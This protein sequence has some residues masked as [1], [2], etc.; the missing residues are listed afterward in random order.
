MVYS[1]IFLFTLLSGIKGLSKK[2][3]SKAPPAPL[4]HLNQIYQGCQTCNPWTLSLSPMGL[5]VGQETWGRACQG[6][7]GPIVHSREWQGA[8]VLMALLALWL[9]ISPALL[10]APWIWTARVLTGWIW[11]GMEDVF[12]PVK[13]I[14]APVVRQSAC[15][16]CCADCYIASFLNAA[17]WVPVDQHMAT[18]CKNAEFLQTV[19]QTYEKT[20]ILGSCFSQI[21]F[22]QNMTAPQKSLFK[23]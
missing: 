8:A 17:H 23:N 11:L 14:L 16:T 5:L 21:G 20:S 1:F 19:C 4:L 9:L 12:H 3:R 2:C 22:Q 13:C 7:Q 15:H 10:L 6:I 18:Y